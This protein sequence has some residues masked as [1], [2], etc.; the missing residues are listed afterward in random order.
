MHTVPAQQLLLLISQ[1]PSGA[2]QLT[3]VSLED[4]TSA[5]PLSCAEPLSLP[6]ASIASGASMV[7]D[8]SLSAPL[9]CG[10]LEASASTLES[11]I[12][13]SR[14]APSL[15]TASSST[16]LSAIGSGV[17]QPANNSAAMT[18]VCVAKA[19]DRVV[20]F[21]RAIVATASQNAQLIPHRESTV[22]A[23]VRCLN[24]LKLK[25]VTTRVAG[26]LQCD[27]RMSDDTGL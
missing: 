2:T 27:R 10:G 21:M 19:S 25:R 6:A 4:G 9:S 5:R 24:P 18:E 26:F 8:A 23:T 22:C 1:R 17:V 14:R 11:V 15:E 20:D 16:P 12:E 7:V 3:P 13:L